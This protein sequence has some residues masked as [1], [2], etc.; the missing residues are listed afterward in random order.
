[1]STEFSASGEH[2]LKSLFVMQ[3]FSE[4]DFFEFSNLFIGCFSSLERLFITTRESG[5]IAVD[6]ICRQGQA[7]RF[8][9]FGPLY[10][11]ENPALSETR[12]DYT[13]TEL[14]AH[15][16]GCP[17]IKEPGV[18]AATLS[19]SAFGAPFSVP[20]GKTFAKALDVLARFPSLRSLRFNHLLTATENRHQDIPS[21]VNAVQ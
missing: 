4:A 7:L 8:F 12:N 20:G 18:H 1:L 11:T 2:A 19:Q 5:R 21:A 16:A 13:A 6:K 3:L 9:H 15:V 17:R 10:R 14:E